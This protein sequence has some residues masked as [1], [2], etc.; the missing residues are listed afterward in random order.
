MIPT[1]PPVQR[2]YV[3]VNVSMAQIRFR[4][5]TPGQNRCPEIWFQIRTGPISRGHKSDTGH[6]FC[7]K[8]GTTFHLPA[9][10]RRWQ[11][12][13]ME[14]GVRR[15]DGEVEERCFPSSSDEELVS[16]ISYIYYISKYRKKKTIWTNSCSVKEGVNTRLL[17]CN[18]LVRSFDVRLV[19]LCDQYFTY[20]FSD[21]Y[22]H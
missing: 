19:F 4:D 14:E 17:N 2:K 11:E 20:A 13:A 15:R 12:A 16:G 1:W 18:Q 3:S 8:S 7:R 9:S 5:D 21:K 6:I 22:K 10:Q